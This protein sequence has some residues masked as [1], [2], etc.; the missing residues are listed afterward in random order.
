MGVPLVGLAQDVRFAWRSLRRTPRVS[1]PVVL[2][3]GI[4][5]A[6]NGVVFGLVRGILLEAFPFR[7]PARLVRIKAVTPTGAE[8][9]LRTSHFGLLRRDATSLAGV[10]A[11][12]PASV[13]LTG[14]GDAVVV[15]AAEVSGAFFSTLGVEPLRGRT[16]TLDD[17][18]PGTRVAIVSHRLWRDRLGGTDVAARALTLDGQ[19][20][21]IVGVMR[22]GMTFPGDQTDVWVPM[23]LISDGFLRQRVLSAASS[24]GMPPVS[25]VA[26][27]SSDQLDRATAELRTLV[28]RLTSPE[29]LSL[30]V[31]PLI[32]E[33][34]GNTRPLLVMAQ[35]GVGVLLLVAV[36]NVT[37]LLLALSS[38][39]RRDYGTRLALGATRFQLARQ[40][41]VECGLLGAVGCGLA[42]AL[43][44]VGMT[45]I[46]LSTPPGLL[47][48]LASITVDHTTW[49]V[50]AL[51]TLTATIVAGLMP[52]LDAMGFDAAGMMSGA[53]RSGVATASGRRTA[54]LRALASI[55]T[56]GAVIFSAAAVFLVL[57]LRAATAPHP[58]FDA[59]RVTTARLDLPGFK[60]LD[61]RER[62]LL[63]RRVGHD[64]V[65]AGAAIVGAIDVLPFAKAD[66]ARPLVGVPVE[67]SLEH[68]PAIRR[69]VAGNYFAA[70]RIP[71]LQGRY[72]GGQDDET[73]PLSAVV[74]ESFARRHLLPGRAIGARITYD[75][76]QYEV[77]G[78]VGDVKTAA[79]IEQPEPTVYTSIH[80]LPAATD[81][82]IPG[83]FLLPSLYLVTRSAADLPYGEIIQAVLRRIDPELVATDILTMEARVAL[84]S[85]RPA[86]A[87]LALTSLA[88]ATVVLCF[89][90][91]Y[92][93]L[94]Y[95]VARRRREFAVRQALG[96]AAP[97]IARLV[98]GSGLAILLLGA[99]AGAV[100]WWWSLGLLRAVL[101]PV[102]VPAAPPLLIAAGSVALVSVLAWWR[103]T[104]QALAVDP[105]AALKA[106]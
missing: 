51:L 100:A 58:G 74:S 76:V 46:K 89:V 42:L 90:G 11:Y 53:D 75:H 32:D 20:F 6:A 35:L 15:A 60:Y 105:V 30:Q 94:G 18:R 87:R 57:G 102:N 45:T 95:A 52:A 44:Q 13:T 77:V 86:F 98:T 104:M 23:G 8:R 66:V 31:V 80:Q 84:W 61:L 55:Q 9:P 99:T 14:H 28:S 10:A 62:L 5:I 21:T 93:T 19:P 71:L 12:D 38:E 65:E 37:G 4:A 29:P 50:A 47:P 83:P 97:D 22:E 59:S 85:A 72:L 25:I 41:M 96:A 103:P 69:R 79:L 48:R 3:F 81:P 64:L 36:A 73:M 16:F 1:I 49:M 17:E 88:G 54:V 92:G 33:I 70:M 40:S 27:L 63:E 2:T 101:P 56:A 106:E 26:R 24:T 78:V 68:V 34:V 7:E 43:T 91:V 39:R 67:A 82:R